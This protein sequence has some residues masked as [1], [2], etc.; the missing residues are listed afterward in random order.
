MPFEEKLPEWNAV[1]VE[2]PPEKKTNG[3]DPGEKPPADYWNW[4]MHRTYKALQELQQKALHRDD[5]TAADIPAEGG[6]NVQEEINNLKS[7][8]SDGKAL[9]AGAITDKGVPTSPSDTFQQ[10]ADNI[11]AIRTGPD[12]SDATATAADILAGK[13]AYGAGDQRL[14]GTMPNRTGH[15]TGQSISRSGTTLRIRPQPGYYPGDAANSVQ[16]DDPNWIAA[17]IRE[18]V[19][20]FGLVGT[21]VPA[22]AASGTMTKGTEGVVTVTGLA[23]RPDVIIVQQGYNPDVG[24]TNR[25]QKVYVSTGFPELNRIRTYYT[26]YPNLTEN[27]DGFFFSPTEWV[28]N[29]DGFQVT[30]NTVASTIRWYAFKLG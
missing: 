28:I 26:Q 27:A 14:V 20:I 4:Q 1:G 24:Y 19:S 8:V 2:P 6:T 5:V 9:V 16:W 3:W 21:L 15:V 10:M 18:G 13:V 23:F 12:T 25:E 17:N 22:Q 11:R 7:Y 29:N 30:V